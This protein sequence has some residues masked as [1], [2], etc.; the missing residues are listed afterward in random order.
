MKPAGPA[1][2]R[3]RLSTGRSTSA[4]TTAPPPSS[5]HQ[6]ASRRTPASRSGSGSGAVCLRVVGSGR[7][8]LG[9][10]VG[11]ECQWSGEGVVRL[12]LAGAE[13]PVRDVR[14][15]V[16][17]QHQPGHGLR[18]GV[19]REVPEDQREQAA[20]LG[21]GP[22]GGRLGEQAG[23]AVDR[24]RHTAGGRR[25][26]VGGGVLEH[27]VV[28]VGAAGPGHRGVHRQHVLV[29]RRVDDVAGVLARLELVEVA[30]DEERLGLLRRPVPGRRHGHDT[31]LPEPVDPVLQRLV[32]ARR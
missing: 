2:P 30:R 5:P 20:H 28:R 18:R 4:S 13:E 3:R 9:R 16:G 10:A 11:V 6:T 22:R 12:D 19:V 31:G 27:V 24:V 15:P 26:H 32:R 1:H 23:A 8:L 17:G 7:G 25:G 21:G 29:R 14:A